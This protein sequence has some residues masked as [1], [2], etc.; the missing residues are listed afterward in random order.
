MSQVFA[1]SFIPKYCNEKLVWYD[2]DYDFIDLNRW[3]EFDKDKD[4]YIATVNVTS[5]SK[6]YRD[7]GFK[8]KPGSLKKTVQFSE[9][10]LQKFDEDIKKVKT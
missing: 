6:I 9:S 4:F 1:N 8:P 3:K 10:E 7:I 5:F 2:R